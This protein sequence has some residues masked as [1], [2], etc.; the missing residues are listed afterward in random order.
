MRK[1]Q[2]GD[3]TVTKI[4]EIESVGGATWIL[5]DATPEA[6]QEIDWLKPQFMDDAVGVWIDGCPKILPNRSLLPPNKSPNAAKISSN[7]P[8]PCCPPPIPACPN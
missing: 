2:I 5:P 4:V 7:P 3:V 6:V 1:W 8:K